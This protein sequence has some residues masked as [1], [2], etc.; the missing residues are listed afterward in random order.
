MVTGGV[1]TTGVT[2]VGGVTTEAAQTGRVTLFVSN[3]TAP[4]RANK[5]PLIEAPV[6]AVTEV[7]AMILPANVEL[8]PRVA[9][10]PTS[11]KTLQACAPLSRM[12]LLDGAVVKV[13]PL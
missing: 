10:E 12:T 1:V 11:Q 5:R 2:G 3:V 13:D 8:V 9:E 6:V 4:L 7:K